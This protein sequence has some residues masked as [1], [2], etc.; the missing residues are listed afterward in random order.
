[1]SITPH[2][3]LGAVAI[4]MGASL[5]MD[6]WNLLL[7]RVFGVP[8]LKYCLLGRWF[9]HMPDGTFFHSSIAAASPRRFE[10]AAGWV[11]HYT[12][13][14]VLALLFLTLA[15][16]DWLQRPTLLHALL[17]GVGTVVFPLFVLQPA[18]GL[19]IASSKTPRPAQARLKSLVT[20]VVFG[21]GLYLCAL[22]ISR[23]P[24]SA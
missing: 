18:L 13:G 23:V 21:V 24:V 3:V 7:K 5:L 2:H 12:I 6:A 8:S 19:G 1:M 16:A 22:A 11:A 20:H 9:L 17:Y 14:V 10:C 4:G 15:P